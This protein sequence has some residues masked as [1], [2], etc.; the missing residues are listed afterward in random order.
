MLVWLFAYAGGIGKS[1]NT[2]AGLVRKYYRGK[3]GLRAITRGAQKADASVG[4]R[5]RHEAENQLRKEAK[6][7]IRNRAFGTFE[8]ATNET[9]PST[10]APALPIGVGN[11]I[12]SPPAS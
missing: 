11:D 1:G 5:R 6:F 3:T 10:S 9:V 7:C 4:L 8:I 12:D 2:S